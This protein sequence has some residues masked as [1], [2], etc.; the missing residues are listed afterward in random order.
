MMDY[1]KNQLGSLSEDEQE[2]DVIDRDLQ[3]EEFIHQ[4]TIEYIKQD[5]SFATHK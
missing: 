4:H 3:H 5:I 1:N 2:F